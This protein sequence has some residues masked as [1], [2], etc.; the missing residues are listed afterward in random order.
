MLFKASLP[1]TNVS[2]DEPNEAEGPL[3]VKLLAIVPGVELPLRDE[4]GRAVATFAA[5]EDLIKVAVSASR[6]GLLTLNHQDPIQSRIGVFSSVSYDEGFVVN[7][8][9]LCPKWKE[10]IVSGNYTGISVEGSIEG[11]MT[12]PSKM[13]IYAVS[14]LDKA[15]GACPLEDEDG[16]PVCK[17]DVIMDEDEIIEAAWDGQAAEKAIWA[18]ATDKNGDIIASKAKKCFLK[19]EG[20]P[21]V[22]ESYSYPYVRI[23]NGTTAP[24]REALIAAL[25]YA[26]GARGADKDSSLIRRIKRVMTREGMELPPSL[27]ARLEQKSIIE[28]GQNKITASVF[29]PTTDELIDSKE[30]IIINVKGAEIMPESEKIVETKVEAEAETVVEAA[31]VEA[32]AETPVEPIVE[33]NSAPEVVAEAPIVEAPSTPAAADIPAAP[34]VVELDIWDVIR[35]ELGINSKEDFVQLKTAA[36]QFAETK[37]NLDTILSENA[38]LKSFKIDT[39]KKWL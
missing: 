24:N 4:N 6:G 33:A 29:D 23:N 19:V 17:V 34:V 26:S 9:V 25:K 15:N 18:Y 39:E 27:Q 20:D 7:G 31:V 21:K 13:E 32:P 16:N 1:G 11:E 12:S 30:I 10:N 2:F 38:G 5:S 28:N 35:K 3:K 14:F 37:K 36:D 8:E 22:K